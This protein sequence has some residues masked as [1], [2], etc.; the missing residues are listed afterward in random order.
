MVKG[1]VFEHLET[2]VTSTIGFK[3]KTLNCGVFNLVPASLPSQKLDVK[4]GQLTMVDLEDTGFG[5]WFINGN[6]GTEN[7][8][9]SRVLSASFT[10][11]DEV[12]VAT[13]Q[14]QS[15]PHQGLDWV[16]RNQNWYLVL[17]RQGI[18]LV[19]TARLRFEPYNEQD[20]EQQWFMDSLAAQMPSCALPLTDWKTEPHHKR[21]VKGTYQFCSFICRKTPSCTHWTSFFDGSC[22]LYHQPN[23]LAAPDPPVKKSGI[24]GSR[25]NVDCKMGKHF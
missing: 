19:L 17:K 20:Q 21:E 23:Y 4:D 10:A 13:L 24:F 16:S 5:G 11:T 14:H 9:Q 6:Q 15:S 1:D 18:E 25:G 3:T 2:S 8:E 12:V 7:V 22:S